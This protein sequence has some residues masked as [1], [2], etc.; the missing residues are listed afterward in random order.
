[1][2]TRGYIETS[3][4]RTVSILFC[5]F[6]VAGTVVA[7]GEEAKPKANPEREP[8]LGGH[9]PASYL[10]SGKAVKGDPAHRSIYMNKTYYLASA[11]VKKQFDADPEKFLPQFGG[12]CTTALGGSYGNRMPSDPKVFAIADGKL[13]LF[14]SER[15]K[16]AYETNPQRFIAR[17]T[18]VFDQAALEG[19]CPVSYQLVN[20]AV[21]GNAEFTYLY[22]KD[23]YRLAG[24]KE[25]A[26]FDKNP[27][28]YLPQFDG[29]CTE[30]VTR[31]KRYPGDPLVFAVVDGKLY[32]FFDPAAKKKF[33]ADVTDAIKKAN[34]G[35]R[36]L[37]QGD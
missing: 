4:P 16:R 35:W 10:L 30:A 28:K 31:G 23:L 21:K 29:Y 12:L 25:R 22:G 19:Y 24:A 1:M 2:K 13:Y 17:A 3:L 11:E 5:A 6:V 8:A 32:L 14:S 26:A 33:D 34:A 7:R 20:K 27:R 9:C 15:A 36:A 37:I 18:A